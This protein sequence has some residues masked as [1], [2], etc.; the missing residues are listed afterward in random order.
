MFVIHEQVPAK[1]KSADSIESTAQKL[2]YEIF[3]D[4]IENLVAI[5][6]A[7][8]SVYL[9]SCSSEMITQIK[10]LNQ[11]ESKQLNTA[12]GGEKREATN[13]NFDPLCT[14]YFRGIDSLAGT[15]SWYQYCSV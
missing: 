3:Q 9:L 6:T 14:D 11:E 15:K 12:S 4:V 1:L 7:G 5:I 13:S 8:Y 10:L 2:E